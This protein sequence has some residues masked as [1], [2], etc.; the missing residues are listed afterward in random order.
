MPKL[1]EEQ[2]NATEQ[3]QDDSIYKFGGLGKIKHGKSFLNIPVGLEQA[4]PSADSACFVPSLPQ[5]TK[6]RLESNLKKSSK[7]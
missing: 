2:D 5:P 4:D 7:S 6:D 3:R 1:G